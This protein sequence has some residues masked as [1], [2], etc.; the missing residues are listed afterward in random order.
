MRLRKL[1]CTRARHGYLRLHILV[2][3]EVWKV[4]SKRVHRIYCKER[5]T[6]RTR[7]PR[8][9]KGCQA[10]VGHP[11][12]RQTNGCQSMDFMADELIDGR[13]PRV[14]TV[15]KDFT[16]ER[17]AMEAEQSLKERHLPPVLTRIGTQ[18]GLPVGDD[19]QLEP[20]DVTISA[21]VGT[22][23]SGVP[24]QALNFPKRLTVSELQVS[25]RRLGHLLPRS[26]PQ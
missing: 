16:R 17:P 4:N 6:M 26:L 12:A 20:I 5:L 2:Q 23:S 3:R 9:R 18:R 1:A 25:V 11:V 14:L 7:T 21:A 19:M 8:L 22:T 10:R 15:V 13:R 24:K